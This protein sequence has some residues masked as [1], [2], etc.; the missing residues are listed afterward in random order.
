MK[1]GT[2]PDAGRTRRVATLDGLVAGLLGGLAV[3]LFF[4]VL[5]VSRGDPA[6]TP[7]ALASAVLG[8][9]PEALGAPHIAGFIAL[10]LVVFAIV[11][12]GA[13]WLFRLAKVPENVPL[14]AVYGLFVYT[15]LFYFALSLS[16]IPVLEVPGWPAVMGGNLLAGVVMGAY[17]H[18]V[19]PLHGHRGLMRDHPVLREGM[20]V[21]LLGAVVLAVWFLV[22]DLIAGEP[23]RTSATL[24]SM[25]FLPTGGPEAVVRSPS[26]VL[27]YAAVHVAGFLV[28]GVVLAGSVTGLELFPGLASAIL[29]LFVFFGV[30][31]VGMVVTVG[32]WIL[33]ELSIWSILV[34]SLLTAGVMVGYLWRVHPTLRDEI[35]TG[36]LWEEL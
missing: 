8:L 12:G 35:R 1:E 31:F 7:T 23:F 19:G 9:T 17:L 32:V 30:A 3:V 13:V 21:G 26:M 22:T 29:L 24:G 34:G 2:A 4:L 6:R 11:G 27:G 16:D 5:D 36:G 20:I 10:Q 28:I 25:L 15:L 18:R 33:E 14:G